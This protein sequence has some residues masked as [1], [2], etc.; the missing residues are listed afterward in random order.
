MFALR[1][2]VAGYRYYQELIT[3]ADKEIQHHLADLKTPRDVTLKPPTRTKKT[4]YQR[5]HYE[6]KTFDLRTELHRIFGVDLT[7]VP[8]ISAVTAHTILCEVVGMIAAFVISS[9]KS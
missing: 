6:P 5:Q 7:D 3:E 8:G 2:S 4:A 1:Q 9:Q